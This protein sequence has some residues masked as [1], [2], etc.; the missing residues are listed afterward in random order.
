MCCR[1]RVRIRG[2][3]LDERK[4]WLQ[5][6]MPRMDSRLL[7][8]D[9]VVGRGLDLFREVCRR[10]LE[11]IVAKWRFGR[12]HSDGIT[13]TWFKVKN[14]TYSQGIDRSDIFAPRRSMSAAQRF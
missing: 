11:G 14:P 1:S 13:T 3:L 9:H 4:R 10:D 2:A 12:Y 5:A 7:Y 6:V 8:M